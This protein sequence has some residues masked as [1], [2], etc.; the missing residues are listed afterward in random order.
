MI[1][2]TNGGLSPIIDTLVKTLNSTG[3]GHRIRIILVNRIGCSDGWHISNTAFAICNIGLTAGK[4]IKIIDSFSIPL[5]G[6]L[7]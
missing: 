3:K 2:L 5:F 4:E 7:F 6:F 1:F